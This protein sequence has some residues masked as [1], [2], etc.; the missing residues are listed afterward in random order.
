MLLPCF[1]DDDRT[2]TTQKEV[3]PALKFSMMYWRLKHLQG[4]GGLQLAEQPCSWVPLVSCA[5][6]ECGLELLLHQWKDI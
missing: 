4:R 2:H 5:A 1:N 3:Y 6:I